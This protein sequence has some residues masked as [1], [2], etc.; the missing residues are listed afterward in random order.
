MS[1]EQDEKEPKLIID[2]DW[3]T[4]V[5]KEKDALAAKEAAKD[6]TAKEPAD[7]A[8]DETT[9]ADAEDSPADGD[10]EPPPASFEMLIA[11]LGSQ[12][13]ISLGKVPNPMTGKP[14]PN[15]AYARHYIDTIAMLK[16][17][18]RRNLTGQEDDAITQTLHQLRMLFVSM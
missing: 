4:Q 12:A 5:Q 6:E 16:E 15:K 11:M 18:T 3:K 14:E 7:V 17:K 13:L 1:E 9:P 10:I 8:A 2:E